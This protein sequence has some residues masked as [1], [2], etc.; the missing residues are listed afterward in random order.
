MITQAEKALARVTDEAMCG[1]MNFLQWKRPDQVCS[2]AQFDAYI[3]ACAG[4]S[5]E[6]FYKIP[7]MTNLADT[8]TTWRWDSPHPGPYAE[9]NRTRVE[10]YPCEQGPTAPTVILLHALMSAND[11]GYFRTAR[12]FNARGWNAAFPHLPLHYS[13]TPRGFMNGELAIT[14]DLVRTGETLRQSV[15]E[16]RQL[17]AHLR[18]QGCREF[19]LT[20]TSWGGWNASL[21]SFVEPDFR[22]VALIQPIVDVEHAIWHNPTARAMRRLLRANAIRPGESNHHNHLTSPR[23]GTPLCGGER[24]IFTAGT[25]DT[26]AP[27]AEIAEVAAQWKGSKL[28]T[29]RQGHFGYAAMPATLREIEGRL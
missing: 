29:V 27:L 20:G 5:R 10:W 3:A 23:H 7:P 25:Y 19:G 17:M 21:L 18:A 9:S 8:P 26:I 4:L 6:E 1:M 13:R 14:A 16:L 15:K 22:F 2:R 28:L 24:M 11:A 12:W